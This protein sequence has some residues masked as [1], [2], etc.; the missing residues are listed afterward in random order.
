VSTPQ[1]ALEG[2]PAPEER[3]ARARPPLGRQGDSVGSVIDINE[4][5]EA[6][7]LFRR[8]TY[9]LQ[10]LLFDISAKKSLRSCCR[11]V[12]KGGG[13]VELWRSRKTGAPH[14]EGLQR[15]GSVWLCPVCAHKISATRREEIE[16]IGLLH[17]EAGGSL[18]WLTLTVRHDAGM[19][20]RRLRK[21]VSEAWR[22]VQQ[23]RAYRRITVELGL[24]GTL[25]ALEVTHG[26][27]GFHPHLHIALFFKGEIRE[28]VTRESGY[29]W[30]EELG[31]KVK[32]FGPS[33]TETPQQ[34]LDGLADVVFRA[35]S[36]A[37]QYRGN[38][39]PLREYG[40]KIEM[41]RPGS[42][43]WKRYMVKIGFEFTSTHKQGRGRRGARSMRD[44]NRSL[45][46]VARDAG[47]AWRRSW[48]EGINPIYF[49]EGTDE[50]RC[51]I[52][53]VEVWWEYEKM[54]SGARQLEWSRKLKR[55]YGIGD[56][57]DLDLVEV[58]EPD[59][60]LLV[61]FTKGHSNTWWKVLVRRGRK[62]E[63]VEAGWEGHAAVQ[64]LL[65]SW[66]ID[67]D[68]DVELGAEGRLPD[69]EGDW[70][71]ADSQAPPGAGEGW[72][73]QRVQ[74]DFDKPLR[75]CVWAKDNLRMEG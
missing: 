10:S 21:D 17:E 59:K 29:E 36:D 30:D 37:L 60:E 32:W 22:A 26:K 20:P 73:V 71:L 34:V 48:M 57:T 8:A 46:E 31:R 72:E 7:N 6:A 49:E 75:T 33:L 63:L 40:A 15:C 24:V 41:M 70:E 56:Q 5:A 68:N 23:S 74:V 28:R 16:R 62:A 58:G 2:I 35:W 14:F 54:I 12:I 39:A 53:D 1:L 66:G 25:R 18:A 3:R 42:R 43:E 4:R 47:T 38:P 19:A 61:R 67:L 51:R 45:W 27:N 52:A 50:P 64:R 65:A 9:D 44:D 13:G 55:L 69:I 11:N